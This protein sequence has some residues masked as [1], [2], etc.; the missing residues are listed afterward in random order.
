MLNIFKMTKISHRIFLFLS[1]IPSFFFRFHIFLFEF[2]VFRFQIFQFSVSFLIR[3][4]NLLLPS[5]F[6]VSFFLPLRFPWTFNEY[7]V[8]SNDHFKY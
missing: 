7:E 6:S 4:H 5:R 8:Y 3:F 1:N 2:P